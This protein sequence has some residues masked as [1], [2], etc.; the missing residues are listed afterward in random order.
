MGPSRRDQCGESDPRR[1]EGIGGQRPVH[2]SLLSCRTSGEN[3]GV[4]LTTSIPPVRRAVA[5]CD[6]GT[7]EAQPRYAIPQPTRE[8]GVVP[9]LMRRFVEVLDHNGEGAAL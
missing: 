7:R 1:G 2:L 9:R 6:G 3:Q 5:P 4:A 8:I